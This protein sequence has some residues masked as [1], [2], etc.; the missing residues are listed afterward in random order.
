MPSVLENET[1]RDRVV[2]WSKRRL[3]SSTEYGV[4]KLTIVRAKARR[5]E[6][7]KD[8][9]PSSC[10]GKRSMMIKHKET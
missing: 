4:D 8:D 2:V 7:R 9:R 3:V 6:T 5:E 1:I 10:P